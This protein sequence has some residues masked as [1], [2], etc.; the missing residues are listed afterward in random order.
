MGF[1]NEK[2]SQEDIALYGLKKLYKKYGEFP[3][4]SWIIDREADLWLLPIKQI[5]STDF[6]WI[7]HYKKRD[8]Q[9]QLCKTQTGWDIIYIEN[10]PLENIKIIQN[11]HEAL[12][13]FKNDN[14]K[15]EKKP[16][17]KNR[18]KTYKYLAFAMLFSTLFISYLIN[19]TK[20][21]TIETP[22]QTPQ[23]DIYKKYNVT[24]KL[25][26]LRGYGLVPN[27]DTCYDTDE[28]FKSLAI[29]FAS[30]MK[31]TKNQFEI[32]IERW[33]GYTK[34]QE[35]LQKKYQLKALPLLWEIEKKVWILETFVGE[36][37]FKDKIEAKLE[38][39]AKSLQEGYPSITKRDRY[40]EPYIK[41]YYK[42]M[43]DRYRAFFSI[44]AFYKT[45]FSDVRH[46]L[47]LDEY[48][49]KNKKA[50]E[51]KVSSYMNDNK[52]LL[53]EKLYLAQQ[54]KILKGVFLKFD[55]IHIVSNIDDLK[56][57]NSIKQIY[58][59]G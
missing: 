13:H 50:F 52:H 11:T 33:S 56:L 51:I 18:T 39:N 12:K 25:P 22:K 35:K 36:K 19:E 21:K 32:F 41:E 34:M 55:S 20:T 28:K 10:T 24:G 9:L 7:L 14:L 37:V 53:S 59:K 16:V 5:D 47:G 45:L 4:E 23:A 3:L 57:R 6:I 27:T 17:V 58:N 43:V 42:D 46:D 2:I 8:I 31:K 44:K 29:E 26:L 15:T 38:E 30:D 54:M 48:V 40:N 1:I 49:V